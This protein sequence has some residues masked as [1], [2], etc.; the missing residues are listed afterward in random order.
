[1]TEAIEVG[2]GRVLAGLVKRIAPSIQM[3]GASDPTSIAG[4]VGA[5]VATLPAMEVR[6]G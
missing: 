1:V 2:A 3:Y 6:H 5:P 4:L